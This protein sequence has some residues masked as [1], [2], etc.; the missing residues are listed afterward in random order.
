MPIYTTF[1]LLADGYVPLVQTGILLFW[2]KQLSP[3]KKRKENQENTKGRTWVRNGAVISKLYIRNRSLPDWITE[4]ASE[5][6]LCD[7]LGMLVIVM[8]DST[9]W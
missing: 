3:I 1:L 8:F 9:C 7:I 5:K 4:Y 2:H 6:S